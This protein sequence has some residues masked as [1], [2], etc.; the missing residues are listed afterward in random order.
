[1]NNIPMKNTFTYK[2]AITIRVES[3]TK[4]SLEYLKGLGVDTA[5]LCRKAIDEYIKQAQDKLEN[6]C[7][8]A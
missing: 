3:D 2:E 8:Q 6:N 7:K 5:S 1:M 4:K